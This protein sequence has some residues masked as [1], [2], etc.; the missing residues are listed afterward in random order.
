M[1]TI[2]RVAG[3]LGWMLLASGCSFCPQICTNSTCGP[4]ATSCPAPCAKDAA[5]GPCATSCPA[6]CDAETCGPPAPACCVKPGII[7]PKSTCAERSTSDN[8]LGKLVA[9]LTY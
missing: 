4:C 7:V 6:H 1:R 8:C 9:F 5:C 2:W 3:G